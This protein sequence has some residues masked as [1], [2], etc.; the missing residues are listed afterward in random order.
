[1]KAQ[2]I[3]HKDI[4]WVPIA[5]SIVVVPVRKNVMDFELDPVGSRRFF[6]VWLK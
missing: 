1:M 2:E 5:H 3:F 6:K 4:P